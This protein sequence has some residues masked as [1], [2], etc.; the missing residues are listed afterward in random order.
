MTTPD[1]QSPS[2]PAPTSTLYRGLDKLT[3][4]SVALL[5]ISALLTLF[6]V[7]F[8]RQG[9]SYFGITIPTFFE[10]SKDPEA[11]SMWTNH[12]VR[13]YTWRLGWAFQILLPAL[14]LLVTGQLLICR[15]KRSWISAALWLSLGLAFFSIFYY[16][17][18]GAFE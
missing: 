3:K 9:W 12:I 11:N 10:F 14:F 18:G 13:I 16:Y 2:V 4:A 15:A 6:L 7:A 8:S 17:F 1:Y 5:G